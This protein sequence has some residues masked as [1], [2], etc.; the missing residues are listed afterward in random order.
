MDIYLFFLLFT[1]VQL[2]ILIFTV[3]TGLTTAIFFKIWKKIWIDINIMFVPWT[4][5]K[6]VEYPK[7]LSKVTW[8]R[9]F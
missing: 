5:V 9:D 8:K 7:N 3:A 1:A 4:S 2:N 6:F